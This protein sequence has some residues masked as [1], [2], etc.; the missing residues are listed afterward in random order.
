MGGFFAPKGPNPAEMQAAQE[1][2]AK[3]E[4]DR[5]AQE[6]FAKTTAE[7]DKL[8]KTMADAESRRRAFTGTFEKQGDNTQRRRYL[9]PA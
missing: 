4:R 5:L 2:A 8:K 7:E 1:A 3:K 9:Q 6:E